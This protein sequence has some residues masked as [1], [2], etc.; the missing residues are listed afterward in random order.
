MPPEPITSHRGQ[1]APHRSASRR[2]YKQN[3]GASGAPSREPVDELRG[4]L[5]VASTE[6]LSRYL[7]LRQKNRLKK[8]RKTK[9]RVPVFST[10]VPVIGARAWPEGVWRKVGLYFATWPLVGTALGLTTPIGFIHFPLQRVLRAIEPYVGITPPKDVIQSPPPT[11]VT[12]PLSEQYNQTDA[13]GNADPDRELVNR[14]LDAIE[15][16][17]I[18]GQTVERI[19]VEGIASDTWRADPDGGLGHSDLIMRDWPMPGP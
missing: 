12:W 2:V 18:S 1:R 9:V 13:I 16:A 10:N 19:H 3:I 11:H 4:P 15:S 5:D 6:A 14:L 8:Q 7:E 17:D